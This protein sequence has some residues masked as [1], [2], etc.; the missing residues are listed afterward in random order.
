M[1]RPVVGNPFENQIATVSPTASPVDVY[2]RPVVEKSPLEAL[3]TTLSR[4]EQK[5]LPALQAEEKR[6]AEREFA[7]GQRLYQENRIALGQA[8]KDGLIDEGASPYLK[9]GYRISQMNTLGMRY[10]AELESALERQKLY[11]TDDPARIEKFIA[12]FQEDFMNKNGMADFAPH[13]VAQ[14]FGTT[15]A[16]G[17]EVFRTAWREKH[18]GWQREQNY[19][20]FQK[21]VA[22][23]TIGL[24]KP[25][26]SIEQRKKAMANFSTW[27][28]GRAKSASVDGMKNSQILDTILTG[29]GVAVEQSGETDVLD[30][31]KQTKFGTAAAASSLKVQAKILDIEAKAL[32]MEEARAR[33][34]E[35]ELDDAFETARA[36]TRAISESYY[37]EPTEQNRTALEDAISTLMATPDDGNTAL[38]IALRKELDAYDKAFISGANNKT[39]QSELRI[40]ASLQK[41]KTY[42]EATAIIL[43][44]SNLGE[45]T[46]ADVSAKLSL[47]RTNF[48]PAL[49][50]AFSLN[51]NTTS[52]EE[53]RMLS[54]LEF[55]VRGNEYDYSSARAIRAAEEGYKFRQQVRAGIQLFIDTNGREPVAF[56]RDEIAYNIS[57]QIFD[58]LQ[59]DGVLDPLEEDKE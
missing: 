5:A 6:R 55:A 11:T 38:G 8:V 28:E 16:K 23:T 14:Y 21:E 32:R 9:K 39:P 3:A 19:L 49:D 51:F 59:T 44:A 37:A 13:E 43:Q 4:L 54:Q 36:T 31:F 58:R 22:E 1:A 27:L 45:L 24:F 34:E 42:E 50:N 10:T 48:D 15:A 35:K 41:A 56:E 47:W 7:E 20:A 33:R 17:N 18:V 40:D 12:K 2:T 26:M 53:G 52:T 29:V 46:P 25:D 30:V 57:K